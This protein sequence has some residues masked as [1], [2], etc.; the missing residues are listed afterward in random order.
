MTGDQGFR[1]LP[2]SDPLW[3]NIMFELQGA[4]VG[5]TTSTGPFGQS[6]ELEVCSQPKA[7]TLLGLSKDS[8]A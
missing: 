1:K 3:V 5:S 7:Y 4:D 6:R 8:A 2:S